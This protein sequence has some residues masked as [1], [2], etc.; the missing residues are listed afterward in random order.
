MDEHMAGMRL[1]GYWYDSATFGQSLYCPASEMHQLSMGCGP[2]QCSYAMFPA[3]LSRSSRILPILTNP[4]GFRYCATHALAAYLRVTNSRSSRSMPDSIYA[5]KACSPAQ[6][7]H[8][9]ACGSYLL[10]QKGT[11]AE[12]ICHR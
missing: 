6:A 3:K 1:L 9:A 4:Q 10:L 8:V 2:H 12:G 5:G 7:M 11:G